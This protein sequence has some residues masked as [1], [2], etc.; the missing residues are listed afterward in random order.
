MDACRFRLT[1]SSLPPPTARD[2][3]G[4]FAGLVLRC[5]WWLGTFAAL[6]GAHWRRMLGIITRR[7]PRK[8]FRGAAQ[9]VCGHAL[10]STRRAQCRARPTPSAWEGRESVASV[11]NSTRRL[12]LHGSSACDVA[13]S[14][15]TPRR[16]QYV[17]DVSSLP[18]PARRDHA[19]SPRIARGPSPLAPR[20]SKRHL[21]GLA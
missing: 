7:Q 1:A 8:G 16:L 3:A 13:C 21:E 4:S 15:E 10:V 17:Q 6:V 2:N 12:Q 18:S 11:D 9:R 5:R 19:T 20:A 14:P